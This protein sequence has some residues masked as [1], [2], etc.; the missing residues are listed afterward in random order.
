MTEILLRG[1]QRR[2]R[3]I[4]APYNKESKI[5]ITVKVARCEQVAQEAAQSPSLTVFDIYLDKALRQPQ[6]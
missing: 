2:Q 3:A 6:L 5:I 1:A 4:A